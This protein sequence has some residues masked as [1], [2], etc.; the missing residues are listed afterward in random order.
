MYPSQTVNLNMEESLRY[1][2]AKPGAVQEGHLNTLIED[3]V[4]TAAQQAWKNPCEIAQFLDD[5]YEKIL[6]EK[7][8]E[9]IFEVEDYI[10]IFQRA[11]EH[12]GVDF[13][14]AGLKGVVLVT[15]FGD[16]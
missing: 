7:V 10:L 6:R 1:L 2:W 14:S 5:A 13:N 9:F 8:I 16:N 3:W 15:Y 11:A 12:F 4:I